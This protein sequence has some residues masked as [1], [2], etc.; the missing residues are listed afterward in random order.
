MLLDDVV[1]V[2]VGG[3]YMQPDESGSFWPVFPPSRGRR[4]GNSWLEGLADTDAGLL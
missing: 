2:A 4:E 3:E 1:A